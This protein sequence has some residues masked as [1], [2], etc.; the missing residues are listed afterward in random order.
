MLYRLAWS[1]IQIGAQATKQSPISALLDGETFGRCSDGHPHFGRCS[2]LT[3]F[4]S[5]MGSSMWPRHLLY[6]FLSAGL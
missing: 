2:T 6:R 4:A 5:D 3:P 1:G